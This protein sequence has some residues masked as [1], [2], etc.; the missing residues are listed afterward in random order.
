MLLPLL[1]LEIYSTLILLQQ[2]TSL[3]L[4]TFGAINFRVRVV[5][6]SKLPLLAIAEPLNCLLIIHHLVIRP[7]IKAVNVVVR[8]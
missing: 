7:V 4:C 5:S 6:H 3:N 2:V 1:L 8:V